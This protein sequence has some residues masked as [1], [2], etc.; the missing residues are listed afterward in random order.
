[1]SEYC[2]ICAKLLTENKTVTVERGMKTLIN[3]SIE[4]GDEFSEFLKNQKSVTIHEDCRKNY[5]RKCSI[6][7]A[8]K[9]Q[10]EKQE[11]STSAERPPRTKLRVN[12]SAF[13]F[14]K[15]CLFCGKELNEE[16]ERKKPLAS[17][18]RISQVSTLQCKDS[19]FKVA[20]A[21]SDAIGEAVLARVH[22]YDLVAVEAKYHHDCYVSFFKPS[23]GGQVGRPKDEAINLA[24]EEIFIYIENS[25]DCQFTLNELRDVCKTT[26][27]DYRTIKI[28]LKL[29]YGENLIITEKSGASTFICLRD[30]HHD[31]LNQAWYEKK[32]G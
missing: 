6:T 12:E 15:L 4:R 14:K 26:T 23:S 8:N 11:A 19:I 21:R 32:N 9:R 24:M 30:N 16:Y 5:T 31:I 10:R 22:E 17:R 3:A 20:R 29:K 25:N 28:R 1:M 7:A 18:R 13:C 27:L 2:F